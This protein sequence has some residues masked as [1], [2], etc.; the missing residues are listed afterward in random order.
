M[1]NILSVLKETEQ[2]LLISRKSGSVSER[3]EVIKFFVDNLKGKTGKPFSARMIAVKLSHFKLGDLYY[4]M[5]V[6]KDIQKCKGQE[7]FQ[8][9]FWWSI[10][11]R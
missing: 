6:C 2:N 4:F 7:S 5:S 8:K 3:A 10:K 11:S 9:Y 1:N